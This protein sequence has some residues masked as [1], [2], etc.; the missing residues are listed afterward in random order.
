METRIAL[1]ICVVL[2]SG[3]SGRAAAQ[4]LRR[5]VQ[6]LEGLAQGLRELRIHMIGM[7]ETVQCALER[8]GCALLESVARGMS[9]GRG[10][11]E[12]W[13]DARD[14]LTRRGSPADALRDEDVRVLDRLFG[15]LGQS[16]REEQT[17]LLDAAIQA[18]DELWDAARRK[19]GEADRLYMSLGVLTGLMLALIVI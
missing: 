7:L 10:A 11:G 6:L 13:R 18:V 15:A 5:R 12:A 14:T 2:G 8:S 16:G 17:A 3:L 19:C 4:A 9:G 1:A